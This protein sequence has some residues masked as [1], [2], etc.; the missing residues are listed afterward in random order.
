MRIMR[1][2][3][4]ILVCV[5]NINSQNAISIVRWIGG[6]AIPVDIA[7]CGDDRVFVVEKAG[8]IRIIENDKLVQAPFL[9]I[10]LKV[11]SSGGEQ[12][13]LGLAFH[14]DYRQN[15]F[16]YVNYTDRSNPTL[17]VIERYKVTSD[18]NKADSTSGQV[19]M[20]FVQ[21]YS[22]H[23]GGC[24]KFGKDGYLYIGTGDGGSANDPQ[25][26]GQNKK[27]R[28]GKMLRIDVDT[29][30]GF[31]IPLTNPFI[32]DTSY[33]K[34]IWAMGLRNPWRYS[35]DEMTGDLWIGDVGQGNW[36]EIDFEPANSTGGK[37]YGWRCYEGNHDFNLNGCNAKTTY[38]FPLHEYLSDENINGCSVTGGYVYRG[39]KYP[40]L[41]GKYLY[42]DY[43]SGK[44]WLLNRMSGNMYTNI[45]AY[46]YTNNVLTTF[47]EDAAGNLYFA[48]A[49]TSSIY[50]IADTCKLKI[51]VITTDP[52]CHGISDGK[53]ITDLPNGE[54]ASFIWSTGDTTRELKNL[55]PG[56]YSVKVIYN[57]CLA[58]TEFII[59]AILPDSMCLTIPNQLTVCEP[60]SI[61]LSACNPVEA[62]SF[63]W[64][65]DGVLQMNLNGKEIWIHESGAYQVAYSDSL[66]CVSL[67]SNPVVINVYSK[68]VAPVLS[69]QRDTLTA[70]AG[71][72]MYEWYLE[73]T[74]INISNENFIKLSTE[75]SYK[76]IAIDSNGCRSNPSL[77]VV[78]IPTQNKNMYQQNATFRIRPNPVQNN[79][80][81]ENEI[82][83]TVDR[84][85]YKIISI[86][87]IEV[88]NGVIRQFKDSANIDVSDLIPGVYW[89]MIQVDRR[90][91]LL[92]FIKANN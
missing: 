25:N 87:D 72:A 53:A 39:D 61:L 14:P 33:L 44:I 76:V 23:N 48:D 63:Q 80:F 49:G 41:Y 50:K 5:S 67:L 92:N 91:E 85:N 20:T 8:K 40:S 3:L 73:D 57:Q 27:S 77:P 21:P 42:G 66:G 64:Y 19:I 46:D 89:L 74:S 1:A 52:S 55:A 70:T 13:L 62:Q 31:K 56:Q 79:L 43:C 68:P 15:G 26:Y 82:I 17:T 10:V 37:N 81:L 84:L 36:E 83:P 60:D 34:E 30:A 4:F 7:N 9:D 78:Y 75:G 18:R 90:S 54:N 32:N 69:L 29:T 58:E 11:R 86:Q 47:G 35:F 65:K 24:L 51:A 2:I 6:V 45:L 71:Y 88:R 59:N 22:N 16:F 28:L 12:G 38:T